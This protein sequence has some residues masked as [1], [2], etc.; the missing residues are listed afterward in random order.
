[1]FIIYTMVG[2]IGLIL[3]G[4]VARGVCVV[5]KRAKEDEEEEEEED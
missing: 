4:V 1:M 5:R 2:I 3:L